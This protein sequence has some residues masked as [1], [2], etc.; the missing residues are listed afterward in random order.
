[1]FWSGDSTPEEQSWHLLGLGVV[2]TCPG[3]SL[4]GG[5]ALVFQWGWYLATPK[6][7]LENKTPGL[8]TRG[9]NVAESWEQLPC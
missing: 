3:P 9:N 5:F 6:F 8:I 4:G 7:Q 1:M 2:E